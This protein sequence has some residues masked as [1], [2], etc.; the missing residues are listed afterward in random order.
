MKLVHL[1]LVVLLFSAKSFSMD[2]D[3][4]RGGGE[5]AK[6]KMK[7]TAPVQRQGSDATLDSMD[8]NPP[9]AIQTESMERFSRWS[10]FGWYF[11]RRLAQTVSVLSQGC[12][13]TC[14]VT[15]SSLNLSESTKSALNTAVGICFVGHIVATHVRSVAD[16]GVRK[17]EA[18]FEAIRQRRTRHAEHP[19]QVVVDDDPEEKPGRLSS[20]PFAGEGVS[21]ESIRVP[22]HL[23][24][25]RGVASGQRVRF[26]G[27]AEALESDETDAALRRG[28]SLPKRLSTKAPKTGVQLEMEDLGMVSD[29]DMAVRQGKRTPCPRKAVGHFRKASSSDEGLAAEDDGADEDGA[30]VIARTNTVPAGQHKKGNSGLGGDVEDQGMVSDS[31]MGVRYGTVNVKRLRTPLHVPLSAASARRHVPTDLPEAA[32]GSA[33]MGQVKGKD[34]KPDDGDG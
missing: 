14:V 1:F 10:V 9:L 5:E 31:D 24:V 33:K 2:P 4:R 25:K 11:L 23:S 28:R 26:A 7:A 22:R 19:I 8:L 3:L 12:G 29:T 27:R 16:K 30:I 21:D 15:A 6:P 13:A 20:H 32:T 34:G 17:N 18:L